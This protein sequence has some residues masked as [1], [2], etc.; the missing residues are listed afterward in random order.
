MNMKGNTIVVT[1][2]RAAL[3]WSWRGSWRSL[4]TWSSSPVAM[5]RSLPRCRRRTPASRPSQRCE[6][7]EGTRTLHAALSR[8][9]HELNVIVNNAG[10][11]RTIKSSN[12]GESLEEL[13]GR[14]RST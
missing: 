14:S 2:A 1:A 7:G 11:M 12:E 13:T 8:D 6:R 9:F 4:A 3:A 10:T 5:R